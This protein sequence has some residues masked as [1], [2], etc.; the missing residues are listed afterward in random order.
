MKV[1]IIGAGNV[2]STLA[3]RIVESGLADVVL[4][5]I[6]KGIAKGKALDISDSLSASSLTGKI[7]GTSEYGDISGSGLAVITAGLARRPGMSREELSLK[8]A[9]IVGSVAS[10]IGDFAPE[11][12]IMVVTNPL[13]A[14]TY[15]AYK[16]SGFAPNRVFGM[17]GLLDESR[18]KA[19]IAEKLSVSPREVE[20]VIL[21]THGDKMVILPR[22]ITVKKKPLDEILSAEEIKTLMDKTR[23]AGAGIV[24]LLGSGSAYYGPS[25]A[26]FLMAKAVIKDEGKIFR[27]SAFLDG[28]YGYKNI[29]MGVP[30]KLGRKGVTDIVDMDLNAEEKAQLDLSAKVIRETIERLKI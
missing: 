25:Q 21:G 22:F 13:D 30:V 7:S 18:F 29:H 2:G 19:F 4:V 8:N 17:A 5:D 20:A 23:S 3:M 10:K 9:D 16:K 24:A 14:M 1:S 28:E 27:A 26:A 6:V 11:S 15:L 12:I